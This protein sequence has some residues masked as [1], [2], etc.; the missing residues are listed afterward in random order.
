M[1]HGKMQL[2]DPE[3]LRLLSWGTASKH[4]LGLHS[5]ATAIAMPFANFAPAAATPGTTFSEFPEVLIPGYTSYGL[6]MPYAI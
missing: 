6:S 2:P 5:L 4:L 1:A 3:G